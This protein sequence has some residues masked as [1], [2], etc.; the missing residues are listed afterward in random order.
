[1]TEYLGLVAVLVV[2]TVV[3]VREQIHN[4]RHR[5]ELGEMSEGWGRDL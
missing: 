3:L 1:M 2:S 5:D 4:W